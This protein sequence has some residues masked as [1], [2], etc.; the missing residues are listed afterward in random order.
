MAIEVGSAYVSI[1]PSFKGFGQQVSDQAQKVGDDAGEQLGEAAADGMSE[2]IAEG[3]SDGV[4]KGTQKTRDKS[5]EAGEGAGEDF[6]SE[7][8][9]VMSETDAIKFDSDDAILKSFKDQGAAQKLGVQVDDALADGI[10]SNSS[11]VDDAVTKVSSSAGS[12]GGEEAGREWLKMVDIAIAGSPVLAAGAVAGIGLAFAGLG[13][14]AL[15]SNAQI[16]AGFGQLKTT[17]QH[18][19]STAA[20]PLVP[21]IDEAMAQI[22]HT[23]TELEPQL[24][25]AF[26]GAV[27]VVADVSGGID[28]LARDA[29]PGVV[30]AMH[31]AAPVAQ[32]LEQDFAG[33]G[34]GLAGF[35]RGLSGAG[36]TSGAVS[37][38]HALFQVVDALLPDL[39]KIAGSLATGIGPA[40]SDIA[41]PAV[42]VAGAFTDVVHALPAPV[43]QGLALAVATLWVAWKG[44][45]VLSSVA[46]AFSAASTAA[47]TATT[48]VEA[49]TAATEA[50]GVAADAAGTKYKTFSSFLGGV[51]SSAVDSGKGLLGLGGAA[52][53][54]EAGI[55]DGAVATDTLAGG[56]SGMLGPLGLAAV[57]VTALIPIISHLTD[58]ETNFTKLAPQMGTAL[59]DLASGAQASSTDMSDLTAALA[60]ATGPFG[61]GSNAVKGLDSS[62]ASLATSGHMPQAKQALSALEA[63]VKSGGGNWSQLKG[64]LTQ[65]NEAFAAFTEQKTIDK[66]QTSFT[67]AGYAASQATPYFQGVSFSLQNVNQAAQ[68]TITDLNGADQAWQEWSGNMSSSQALVTVRQDILGLD[69]QAKS[70]GTTLGDN[71]AKGLSNQQ[72]MMQDLSAIQSY[73]QTQ[74]KAT[75]NIKATNA[76]VAEQILNF[77]Q[78]AVKAGYNKTQIDKLIDSTL[79]IPKSKSTKI[80]LAGLE[81]Y[82]NGIDKAHNEAS[83]IA[84]DLVTAVD[85]VEQVQIKSSTKLSA[86]ASGGPVGAGEVYLVGEQGPELLTMGS[87]SGDIIPAA[88]TLDI[89]AQS[90]GLNAVG[91]GPLPGGGGSGATINYFGAPASPQQTAAETAR[92]LSLAGTS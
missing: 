92:R 4:D 23:A 80:T 2:R 85:I 17:V 49:S 45:N 79:G 24:H 89:L 77:E 86:R 69:T 61:Q 76:T 53:T 15:K 51:T 31:A 57:G 68:L 38:L 25:D 29:M 48:S 16:V 91:S 19:L 64:E 28:A 12:K 70:Y 5:K 58:N 72:A 30:S 56:L 62:I 22:G 39:G 21:A 40:L 34:T 18:D 71:T 44:Y 43:I 60:L 13:V 42:A 14:L 26:A 7:F 41:G 1:V 88:Q 55:E 54:A 32:E 35:L 36:A 65:T 37:G 78:S 73:G 11:R 47:V 10:E 87:Q 63:E 50:S 52:G 82:L 67:S 33:L 27:P 6:L 90:R 3:M 84:H 20:A 46:G 8:N 9:R 81:N 75:G 74:L 66:V 59:L 83:K